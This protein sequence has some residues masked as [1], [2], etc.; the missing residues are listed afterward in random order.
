MSIVEAGPA[1]HWYVIHTN[2]GQENR[3]DN[4]LQAWRVETFV[5]LVKGRRQ[6]RFADEPTYIIK[7]LF[8]GYIFARFEARNLLHKVRFTRGVHSV[9]GFG[10][11]PVPVDHEIIS[12][13]RSRMGV[14]GLVRIGD[15][16]RPGDEVV[17]TE[18]PLKDFIGIFERPMKE[19]E[20]VM[21]LLNVVSYQAHVELDR[22]LLKRLSGLR[23]ANA[24]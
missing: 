18:G 12:I 24:S 16:L 13:I 22:N 15:D 14:D 8:T 23:Q 2:P 9:V 17:V 4:N 11:G 20:R 1:P 10:N 21:V 3:A 19:R 7:P 6:N 5:P